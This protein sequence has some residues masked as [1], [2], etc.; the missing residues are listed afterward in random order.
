MSCLLDARNLFVTCALAGDKRELAVLE[1]PSLQS[2]SALPHE[3]PEHAMQVGQDES[4]L[5]GQCR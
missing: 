5:L 1:K 4:P 2:L 3:I